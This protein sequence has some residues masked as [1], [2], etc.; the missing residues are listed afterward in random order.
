MNVRKIFVFSVGPIGAALLGLI[1]LPIVA[2]L[3]SP[4]DIGKLTMLQVTT[5]FTL[6]LFSLGLDQAYVREFHEVKDKPGLLKAVFIPGFLVLIVVLVILTLCPWSLSFL[7]FSDD[8]FFITALLYSVILLTFA[9]RFLSL[10][11][12]MQERGL[13]FS[14]SQLLPKLLFLLIVLGYVWFGTEAIF[15]NLILANFLSILAVF[16]IYVWNTRN[17]WMPALTSTVDRTKQLQMISYAIPLIGSGVAFWGLTAMDKVFLRSLSTFEELGIY[18]ISISFAGA[19]LVF[20]SIFSTVWAPVVYKW[21]REGVPPLRIKNVIDYVTLAVISIWALV[22]VFSWVLAYILPVEYSSV[23]YILLAA[24]AYP[25]LYTLA[26]ATGI[27]VGIK[28]KSMYTLLASIGAL[29][30]NAMGNWY[31]IPIYGA[32]GAALASSISFMLF[33]IVRTESSAALWVRFESKKMYSLICL[34][35]ALSFIVNIFIMGKWLI[36]GLYLM[37]FFLGI[38]FYFEQAKGVWS[39]LVCRLVNVK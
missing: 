9:S 36:V 13:A 31:L 28:R 4:E 25:L 10:I 12:R 15:N 32:A 1:T 14:M 37:M 23:P 7:L 19:A 18:S 33:F 27:G 8:S 21:A 11:L 20:Q 35:V 6:L 34:M 3:F 2:W 16:L 26:E 39:F 17:D 30:V 5:S 38:A 24:I 29:I 22:G